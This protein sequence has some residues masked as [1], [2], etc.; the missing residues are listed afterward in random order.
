MM[1]SIE[2]PSQVDDLDGDGK[3]DEIAF[4]INLG[5]HQ[6]RIVTSSYGE[7]DRI[8]RLRNQY[9][10]RTNA[11]FSSKIEGLGWESERIAFR[12]YFDRRN[13]IDIYGKRQRSLQLRLYSSPDYPYHE[14]SP[15]GRDIFRVG[16]SIGIG[17]VA[18]WIDGKVVKAANV[19]ERKWRI[20]STG[21]VRTMVELEY[22]GWNLGPETITLRSRIVQ[23]AGEHG[24]YH[25][26][27]VVPPSSTE[28]VTGLPV[29]H[30][31]ALLKS[32]PDD[33]DNAAWLATWGEQVV[34]PGATATEATPRQNLGLAVLTEAV[35]RVRR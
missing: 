26:I 35:G 23:W 3:G 8:L 32:I 5:P 31:I 6:T 34:A 12:L 1:D 28:F 18:A 25:S 20:V 30:D 22:G 17:A 15:E 24:F 11:L 29:K 21:P 2:L 4:Q 13:D 33:G 19:R 9:P 10:E 7:A 27:T 14:E 16:D